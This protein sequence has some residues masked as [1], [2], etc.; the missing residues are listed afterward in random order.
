MVVVV[1]GGGGVRGLT[2]SPFILVCSTVCDSCLPLS[3]VLICSRTNVFQFVVF[4]L[5]HVFHLV[6]V[7]YIAIRN[8]TLT[9]QY[10]TNISFFR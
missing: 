6:L 4:L 8:L 7:S 9:L 1:V 10:V 3:F 2:L 5:L